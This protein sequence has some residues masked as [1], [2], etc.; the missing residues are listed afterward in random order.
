MCLQKVDEVALVVHV[1]HGEI[2]DGGQSPKIPF[3]TEPSAGWK[4]P[5]Q[6]A[7]Y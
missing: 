5:P 2:E 6:A 3:G 1:V 4:E 7:L